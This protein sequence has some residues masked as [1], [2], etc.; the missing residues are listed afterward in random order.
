MV[1]L[2]QDQVVQQLKL[3]VIILHL[4][5]IIKTYTEGQCTWYVFDKR[6]A[7]KPISTYWSDAKYWASNAANDGYQVDNTPSVGAIMQST[8]GPYGHVAY[9][10]N[11]DGSILISEMNYANGPY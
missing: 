7:G 2:V 11:G 5:S 4:H 10:R 9:E 6:S 8:P 3:A 1:V